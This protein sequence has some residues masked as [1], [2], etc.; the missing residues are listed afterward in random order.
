MSQFHVFAGSKPA[1]EY[2]HVRRIHYRDVF[3]ALSKGFQDFWA[4]PSH[5][6]FLCLIYPLAG[7]FITYW[8]ANANALPLLF[9]LMSGF[10]LLG[11]FAAIGLYEISRR[12][13]LNEDASWRHALEVWRS[14]SVPAILAIG[15]LLVA[16]FIAWLIVAQ[17]L[18]VEMFGPFAPASLL[19]LMD[20]VLNTPQGHSL[21]WIGNAIGLGFAL[22]TLCTTI[23]AFPL[24]LDRDVGAVAAVCTSV[25]VFFRNPAE[26][27]LWAAIVV[28]LLAVG[29]A[30]FLVGLAIVIPVLG[31]A[32]WH[33]YRK[34]VEAPQL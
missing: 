17:A 21:F 19:A 10:A 20:Q 18:Y 7:L 9:P 1:V 24:L 32:T 22:F 3:S 23:V 13:E 6:V 15:A 26:C 16:V 29:F 4:K 5:Y 12:R 2:P 30:T 28:A 33:L 25:K 14:P 8:S 31:H 11:P 27:L 34:T